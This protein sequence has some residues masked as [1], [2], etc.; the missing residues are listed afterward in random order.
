MKPA[1]AR[2]LAEERTREEL[3][4]AAAH[5]AEEEDPPFE[6]KGEDHGEQLTHV[7]LAQRIRALVDEGQDLKSAYRAVMGEVRGVLTNE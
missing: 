2:R 7:L 1:V 4:A 3:E 5:L 6:V